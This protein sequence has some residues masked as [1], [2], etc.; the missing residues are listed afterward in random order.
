MKIISRLKKFVERRDYLILQ[1]ILFI[2]GIL[3]ILYILY[4]IHYCV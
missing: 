4:Y 3:D 2:F 1:K